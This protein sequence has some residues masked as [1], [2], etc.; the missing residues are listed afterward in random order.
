M[1]DD[2]GPPEHGEPI[3]VVLVDDDALLRAGLRMIIE[4]SHDMVVVGEADDGDLVAG[5]VDRERPDVVLMDIRMP[6]MNGI[7]ATRRLVATRSAARVIMLTTFEME[8]YVFG[9]L[10]AGASG[11]LLKRTRPEDLLAGIR[12]VA[13]GDGLLSPSV[14]RRLIEAFTADAPSAAT[15]DP[16]LD[17]LTDREREVLVKM[18]GG[19]NNDEIAA[20]LYIAQNTVKTHVKRVLG[21]LGARDRVQ[22]VVAAYEGGLMTGP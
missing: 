19:L 5:I 10:R 12:S 11:F 14:T 22:A 8:E 15:R 20:E 7:E 18:A 13:A 21:K 4:Q 3:R 6:G 2:L 17:E 1:T 9:A 16:R